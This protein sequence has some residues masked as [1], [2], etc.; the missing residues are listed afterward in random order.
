[1]S[2]Q[3]VTTTTTTNS[4]ATVAFIFSLIIPIVGLVLGII[5]L[6]RSEQRNGMGRGLSIAAIWISGVFIVISLLSFL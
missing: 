4:I 1:M 2:N 3:T 6:G 5:G